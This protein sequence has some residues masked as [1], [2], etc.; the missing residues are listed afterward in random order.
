MEIILVYPLGLINTSFYVYLSYVNH[1]PGEASVNFYYTIMNIYGWWVWALRNDRR[2]KVL[3]ITFS[4]PKLWRT[5]IAFFLVIFAIVFCG[6]EFGKDAFW[7]GA[8][9]LPDA[10]AT[11]S[12]FTGM[13][14]MTRK[15]VESWYWWIITNIASIPLYYVKGLQLTSVYYFILLILAFSGLAAWKKKARE[16]SN[17]AISNGPLPHTNRN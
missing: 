13:W 5:Q 10:F 11:A 3:H 8:M 9:P 15:K 12:A 1:L 6:I 17:P 14:L 7:D 4:S 2:E 16:N